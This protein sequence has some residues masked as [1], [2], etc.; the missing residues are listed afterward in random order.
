MSRKPK[1]RGWLWLYPTALAGVLCVAPVMAE[2]AQAKATATQPEQSPPKDAM[3]PRHLPYRPTG[4]PARA[5]AFYQVAWGIDKLLV[6]RTA[7]GS[8]VRFSYRV[9]DAERAKPLGDKEA[10][11]HLID[12]GRG[13]ALQVPVMEQVGQLRQT[14]APVVGNQYWMVF[15]NKG[16]VVKAGDRVDVVIGVFHADGLLVQ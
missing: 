8:L 15:S 16:D 9:T 13:V 10:T 12:S 6:R 5:T 11:P 7:S 2:P 14:G 3:A 4:A 1:P